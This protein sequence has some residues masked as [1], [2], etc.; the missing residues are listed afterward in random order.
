MLTG[1]QNMIQLYAAVHYVP[2]HPDDFLF[3]QIDGDSTVRATA[4]S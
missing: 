1:D 2:A 3:R 4:E